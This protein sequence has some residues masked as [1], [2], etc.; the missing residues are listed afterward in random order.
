MYHLMISGI[1]DS[2]LLLQE[3]ED[4][5]KI[6]MATSAINKAVGSFQQAVKAS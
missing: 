3:I 6:R 5:D 4:K 2:Y 1:S